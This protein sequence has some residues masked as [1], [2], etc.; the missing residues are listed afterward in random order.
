V[1]QA[2]ACALGRKKTRQKQTGIWEDWVKQYGDQKN[3]ANLGRY[4]KKGVENSWVGVD[5]RT[6]GN[7][8]FGWDGL[9]FK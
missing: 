5:K 4:N 3:G 8:R 9:K 6:N 2:R 1:K 7:A